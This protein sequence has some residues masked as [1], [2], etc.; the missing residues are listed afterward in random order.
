MAS[1]I[2]SVPFVPEVLT[3]AGLL[4]LLLLLTF[5]LSLAFLLL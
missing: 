2:A 4:L 5:L 3:V 1:L